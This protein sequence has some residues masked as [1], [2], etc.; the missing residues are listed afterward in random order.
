MIEAP[1]LLVNARD[2]RGHGGV[3]GVVGPPEY[4]PRR[5]REVDVVIVVEAVGKLRRV[6]GR[7]VARRGGTQ[8]LL[9]GS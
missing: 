6:N 9:E 4:Q 2:A 1:A 7:G 3:R 8:K 5:R